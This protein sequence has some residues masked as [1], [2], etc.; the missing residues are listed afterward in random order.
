LKDDRA[1]LG[2][3]L[4]CISRIEEYTIEG[5]ETFFS[6]SLIQDRVMR[7]LQTLTSLAIVN[8]SFVRRYPYRVWARNR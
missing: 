2:H 5:R 1:Y 4:R 3:I 7:N 8:L 6:S